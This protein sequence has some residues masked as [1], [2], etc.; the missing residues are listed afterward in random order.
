MNIIQN[1]C[2]QIQIFLLK[3]LQTVDHIFSNGT[4]AFSK[5][6]EKKVR[7]EFI[8]KEK[9]LIKMKTK[10]YRQLESKFDIC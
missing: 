5:Q 8:N 7:K 3:A 6:Q 1:Y 9:L 4:Q 2:H 10:Q